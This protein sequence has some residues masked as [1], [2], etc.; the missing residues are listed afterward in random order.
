MQRLLLLVYM[1]HVL[2][3][4]LCRTEAREELRRQVGTL[5]FDLN[6]LASAKG[7]KASRKAALDLKKNFF[8]KVRWPTSQPNVLDTSRNAGYVACSCPMTYSF[9][10]STPY[11][12]GH[13]AGKGCDI[14]II[15]IIHVISDLNLCTF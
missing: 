4:G 3:T 9:H 10:P 1:A 5:R 12:H 6:T 13:N 11:L 14:D 8:A 7:D 2:R 15:S